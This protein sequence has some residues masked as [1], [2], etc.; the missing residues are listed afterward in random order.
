MIDLIEFCLPF[1]ADN[2]SREFTSRYAI[3]RTWWSAAWHCTKASSHTGL[4]TPT[5]WIRWNWNENS[6]KNWR[7]KKKNRPKKRNF[8]QEIWQIKRLNP[9]THANGLKPTFSIRDKNLE[10][11]SLNA[12]PFKRIRGRNKGTKYIET[13]RWHIK[14]MRTE[15]IKCKYSNGVH[16]SILTVFL[17]SV[18]VYFFFFLSRFIFS[19]ENVWDRVKHKLT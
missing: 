16:K 8:V 4:T 15:S 2:A 17:F 18:C 12:M 13:R 9:F 11:N 6:E 7:K 5:Y 10:N 19:F 1:T 14:W 3:F